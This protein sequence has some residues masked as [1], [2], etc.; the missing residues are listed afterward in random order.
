M[1][2]QVR[3]T[4]KYDAVLLICVLDMQIEKKYKLAISSY[5]S[6]YVDNGA[7]CDTKTTNLTV[8]HLSRRLIGE[9]MG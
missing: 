5:F 8:A 4:R 6:I 1:T 2:N 7:I 9:L 3:D